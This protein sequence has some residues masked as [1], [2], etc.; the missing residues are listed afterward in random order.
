MPDREEME[1][2]LEQQFETVLLNR[3]QLDILRRLMQEK[4]GLEKVNRFIN[5]MQKGGENE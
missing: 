4:D 3:E 5:N 1:Q 2:R